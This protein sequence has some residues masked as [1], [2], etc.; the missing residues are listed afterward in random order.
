MVR[1]LVKRL[2]FPV[3]YFGSQGFDSAQL[4]LTVWQA[5]RVLKTVGL[6]VVAMDCGGA[7][8]N[9]Q[10]Y[11]I[12]EL[13]DGENKSPNRAVYWIYIRFDKRQKIYLFCD[14]L[15]LLET[16]R[17]NFKNLH[18]YSTRNLMVGELSSFL[19]KYRG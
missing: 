7:S 5:I 14:V 9:R 11:R 16:F 13:T 18:G 3:G 19:G 15:H 2:C 1:G 12:H 8:P 6:H 4:F 10:F 17:N